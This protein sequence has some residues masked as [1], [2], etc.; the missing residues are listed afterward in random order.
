MGAAPDA[1]PLHPRRPLVPASGRPP[2]SASFTRS[3][4]VLVGDL[5]TVPAAEHLAPSAAGGGGVGTVGAAAAGGRFL[6]AAQT[7]EAM[8]QS[9][10][11]AA[12]RG[13]Q[14]PPVHPNPVD[15][16]MGGGGGGGGA[17][18]GDSGGGGGAVPSPLPAWV[19]IRRSARAGAPEARIK[20][21]PLRM[22]AN[23][24]V[25]VRRKAADGGYEEQLVRRHRVV[26]VGPVEDGGVKAPVHPSPPSPP[27]PPPPP[28]PPASHPLSAGPATGRND[29][30]RPASPGGR[31]AAPP[32]VTAAVPFYRTG[33][34]GGLAAL[35]D[36]REPAG[37]VLAP[38]MSMASLDRRDSESASAATSHTSASTA[39]VM[40][41]VREGAAARTRA[42]EAAAA[43]DWRRRQAAAAAAAAAKVGHGDGRV[44]LTPPVGQD[45][46]RKGAGHGVGEGGGVSLLP[47][48]RAAAPDL[49]R[50]MGARPTTGRVAGAVGGG[51]VVRTAGTNE[52]ESGPPP[53]QRTDAS[54]SL[55]ASLPPPPGVAPTEK[56]QASVSA[57]NK[58]RAGGRPSWVDLPPTL[59]QALP[60]TLFREEEV[61]LPDGRGGG[62]PRRS[63]P[64][65]VDAHQHREGPARVQELDVSGGGRASPRP[66]PRMP[67]AG[68][69]DVGPKGGSLTLTDA[70]LQAPSM[71][72][73]DDPAS[74][75]TSSW[76]AMQAAAAAS[77]AKAASLERTKEPAPQSG[78]SNMTPFLR[79]VPRAPPGGEAPSAT[80]SPSLERSTPQGMSPRRSGDSSAAGGD[81]SRQ[82]KVPSSDRSR[83]RH[84]PLPRDASS[85]SRDVDELPRPHPPR[86]SSPL[87]EDAPP[88]AATH[89]SIADASPSMPTRH[90]S[91]YRDGADGK[92]GTA[93]G[94]SSRHRHG[95]RRPLES[96]G[97][98]GGRSSDGRTSDGRASDGRTSDGVSPSRRGHVS[99]SRSGA[100]FGSGVR[101]SGDGEANSSRAHA[102][103]RASTAPPSRPSVTTSPPSGPLAVA[104][105]PP[106]LLVGSSSAQ[107]AASPQRGTAAEAS[108]SPAKRDA[109]EA[110]SSSSPVTQP[111]PLGGPWPGAHPPSSRIHP[112]QKVSFA[113]PA[114][115]PELA[116]GVFIESPRMPRV[117]VPADTGSR[118][119]RAVSAEARKERNSGGL[120][121]S[122]DLRRKSAELWRSV[123]GRLRWFGGDEAGRGGSGRGRGRDVSVDV[124][125]LA[126]FREVGAELD[127]QHEEKATAAKGSRRAGATND[128]ARQ[129]A[130][131]RRHHRERTSR[132]PDIAS[133][134]AQSP[135][136]DDRRSRRRE[137][138]RS[139]ELS[140]ATAEAFREP[141]GSQVP[142][143]TTSRQHAR[144][145]RRP[146]GTT[147]ASRSGDVSGEEGSGG[148]RLDGLFGRRRHSG[149]NRDEGAT[150]ATA[151][152]GKEDGGGGGVPLGRMFAR[153]RPSGTRRGDG[154]SGDEGATSGTASGGESGPLSARLFSRRRP[155]G[156][157]DSGTGRGSRADGTAVPRSGSTFF[158]H[159]RHRGSG[160]D[161]GNEDVGATGESTAGA[162]TRERRRDRKERERAA[163]DAAA[164][165][166]RRSGEV[167]PRASTEE[168]HLLLPE[169]SARQAAA[170]A[171][172]HAGYTEE[173]G[174][175]AR[176]VMND[177]R[178]H[179]SGG[180]GGRADRRERKART[181][182]APDG[183]RRRHGRRDGAEAG[184][185]S[186]IFRV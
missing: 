98:G 5:R 160:V 42:A 72:N 110:S 53:L 152:D 155:S 125:G 181:A 138:R 126:D 178:R 64:D 123:S 127:R 146:G 48:S 23:G 184:R 103:P 68:E 15:G 176:A 17:G 105:P 112:P 173:D 70:V 60:P 149:V 38:V 164:R 172:V 19:I 33:G 11:V 179:R 104:A 9:R 47:L 90:A 107:E 83:R 2:L 29:V 158:R 54:A 51:G 21:R 177:D 86:P 41:A 56:R 77:A 49:P 183:R 115:A 97:K 44:E 55:L 150:S 174:A 121:G 111:R 130:R 85:G 171:R 80:A 13:G 50:R 12:T 135:E 89:V 108:S 113:A 114:D 168:R 122:G 147:D 30:T 182:D 159:R 165:E 20:V 27:P 26:Y 14:P 82:A 34:G 145:T 74:D 101:G 106:A 6:S 148:R 157:D 175:A 92:G 4:G 143:A 88:L 166:R 36:A 31:H 65:G 163:A 153:R 116:P 136:S 59:T 39:A 102:L 1:L 162:A 8:L 140:S 124:T 87:L 32:P 139:G 131:R 96:D 62:G 109:A 43:A 7:V 10:P 69:G 144:A 79:V 35:D 16:N 129:S 156:V 91:R 180:W 120:R 117:A 75:R 3:Q 76:V 186:G 93:R 18:G 95:H 169:G 61:G 63:L 100:G 137:A 52:P 45:V 141:S 142:P 119:S 58:G 99:A 22:L 24:D 151:G 71:T 40:R 46:A 170:G 25:V 118:S 67:G 128:D 78:G 57:E 167:T 134:S 132:R 161:G 81:D 185:Q 154:V 133:A 37:A 73:H 66:R 28:R 84:A 94:S